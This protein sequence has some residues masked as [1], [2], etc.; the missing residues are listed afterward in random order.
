MQ[1]RPDNG[2]CFA[3][4]AGREP[5]RS[6]RPGTCAVLLQPPDLRVQPL[7]RAGVL[8]L[9][10]QEVL[11]RTVQLVLQVRG[12]HAD[13]Q[14]TCGTHRPWLLA[15]TKRVTGWQAGRGCCLLTAVGGSVGLLAV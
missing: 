4:A 6:S 12:C 11:L 15:L 13:T 1:N 7:E 8:P 2:F 14:M 3:L 10:E 5:A 9:Q